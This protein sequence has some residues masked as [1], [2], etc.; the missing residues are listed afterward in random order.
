MPRTLAPAAQ[1]PQTA[2]RIITR[3]APHAQDAGTSVLLPV[4]AIDPNPWN[5][6]RFPARP[7]P[8]DLSL[9]ASIARHGV[10]ENLLVRPAA[11]GRYQLV[12]GE[13]RLR[14]AIAAGFAVVPAVVRAMDDH[15][16]RVLTL[17]E[18]L[19][20]SQLGFLDEADAVAGLVDE[21]W[22]LQQV[23]A[24]LG[25]PL[26]WV[27]R[28]RR[29]RNLTPAWR[30]L[31]ERREGWTAAWGA[32][33]FEQIAILEPE[34]QADLLAGSRHRLERCTTARELAQL[35]RSLTRAVGGFPWKPD[36]AD[37]EPVAGA[38]SACPRRSSQHP[39]LF[40]DQ[41]D[42]EEPLGPT[43]PRAPKPRRAA[44]DRCLD[45]V[46]A[47]RKAKLFL[48][49]KVAAL[50]AK[51]PK[52]HLLQD[53]WLPAV[54]P[55]AL[56]EWEVTEVKKGSRGAQPAVVANG[57][58]LGQVRWIK[59]P[60]ARRHPPSPP[61]AAP[62]PAKA[63]LADRQLRKWRQR[64]VHALG[65][66]KAALAFHAPPGLSASVRLAIV[67]G[68][69]QT[70]ASAAF[71]CDGALPLVTP[72]I[73][74][75]RERRR[76]LGVGSGADLESARHTPTAPGAPPPARSPHSAQPATGQAQGAPAET[77]DLDDPRLLDGDRQ[78]SSEAPATAR[79]PA[80]E[81]ISTTIDGDRGASRFWR[82]FDALEG[83]PHACAEL[84]WA[85]TL[86]VMLDRMTPNGDPRHVD[87]AWNEALRVTALVGLDAQTFLDQAA[88]VLP[89]PKSWAK[90]TAASASASSRGADPATEERAARCPP[91]PAVTPPA[92]RRAARRGRAAATPSAPP[93]CLPADA[94]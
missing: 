71:A 29:L 30:K 1:P 19:H 55:G 36:D 47:A 89:D 83:N 59:R 94:A 50:A 21:R 86:R 45:P 91:A 14:S 78:A 43:A 76:M 22:T 56:Q 9:T 68:T 24:E 32:A 63:S 46:C 38:C 77:E 85:R 15:E 62:A 74:L 70:H 27:A 6:R 16:A 81:G 73:D 28:R 34:A 49:R 35:I 17:T 26:S 13:R 31:A 8:E 66:V 3:Q 23:A 90:E 57:A 40:D 11:A 48:E 52:V 5:P 25:K 60:D 92:P 58:N 12:F 69:A 72:G 41:Q 67:F 2:P 75:A 79:V 44:T 87:V 88:A 61:L 82:A 42:A 18:N 93:P 53:G 20:R 51:H 39:G 80:S 10:Q 64:K 4:A 33:D 84:L 37:L 54:L 65:L 7:G